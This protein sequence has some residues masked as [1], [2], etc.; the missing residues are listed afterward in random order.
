M[1]SVRSSIKP[2]REVENSPGWLARIPRVWGMIA[3]RAV[4]QGPEKPSTTPIFSPPA[5]FVLSG[6]LN[7]S[8]SS[9]V[10]KISAD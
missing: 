8:F 4:L 2:R 1:A 5:D 3:Q 10:S 7:L 9:Q 6:L